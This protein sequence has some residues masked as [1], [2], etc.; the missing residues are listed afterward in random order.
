MSA[1]QRVLAVWSLLV[2]AVHYKSHVWDMLVTYAILCIAPYKWISVLANAVQICCGALLFFLY[3]LLRYL[4]QQV[5]WFDIAVE[6]CLHVLG[7]FAES[8][9]AWYS[10]MGCTKMDG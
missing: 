4:V 2:G 1:S 6:A 9:W 8:K 7:N 5:L 10:C 3:H